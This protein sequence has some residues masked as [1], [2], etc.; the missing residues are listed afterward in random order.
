MKLTIKILVGLLFVFVAGLFAT[1]II[2]KKEYDKF[3]KS[4]FYWNFKRVSEQPFK[5]LKIVGGNIT[6]IAF[7]QSADCSV[8]ILNSWLRGNE[9]VV[10]TSVKNDTLFVRFNYAGKTREQMDWWK[11]ITAVR[12]FSPGLLTV[13][14]FD[15]DLEMFK[16]KQKSLQ[17]SMSG[18]SKFEVESSIR[19]LDSLTIS[20]KDSSEVVFEM[21]P[22][23]W[24]TQ[25]ARGIV[26]KHAETGPK[27]RAIINEP[28]N[29]YIKS[30]E[31]MN[32]HYVHAQLEGNTLLDIGHAQVD[33]LQLAI[34]DS[35]AVI[36]SGAALKKYQQYKR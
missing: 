30:P 14:G 3:D 7:E 8:R 26:T 11:Y 24:R 36:L 35:S 33:S 1:N 25:S 23:N 21:S 19:F 28:G 13:E 32:I 31:A 27:V 5:Y 17:V 10:Q 22:D 15:T 29:E 2:L 9:G 34:S 12:I 20:Q 4:D 16:L 18:K 6:H